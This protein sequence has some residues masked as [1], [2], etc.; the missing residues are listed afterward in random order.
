M[1]ILFATKKS[2][3]PQVVGGSQS[4]THDLC[5]MLSG[6]GHTCAVMSELKP[7]DALWLQNRLL[8]KLKRKAFVHDDIPGYRVY[9]G[10][11]VEKHAE[12]VA[13]DFKPDVVI[14]QAGQPVL[15]ANSFIR[16]GYNTAIY[17]RDVAFNKY[18]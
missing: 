9:R 3:L 13:A 7:G 10:W 4:S 8:A 1:R 16:M 12:E 2:H 11:Q 15:V 17:A 14:V 6:R 18:G 5:S